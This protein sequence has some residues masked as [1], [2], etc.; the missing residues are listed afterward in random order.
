MELSL[1]LADHERKVAGA[2]L[3]GQ[4]ADS[5]ASEAGKSGADGLL[6][7][8]RGNQPQDDLARDVLKRYGAFTYRMVL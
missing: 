3:G 6:A 4:N 7:A 2:L 5:A 8:L 1:E